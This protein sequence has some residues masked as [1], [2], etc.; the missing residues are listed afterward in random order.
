MD[1]V[2]YN[3]WLQLAHTLRRRGFNQEE[4]SAE[5][6]QKGTPATLLQEIIEKAKALYTARRRRSGFVCCGI[7]VTLLVVG[8]MLTLFFISNGGNVRL[9][10]YG[11]TTI[12]VA[13]TLKGMV[14]LLGW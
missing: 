9:V 2:N 14:D 6:Q 13:F 1:A 3:K 5:L 4:I 8:C 11:L 10:M 12:G 7:G